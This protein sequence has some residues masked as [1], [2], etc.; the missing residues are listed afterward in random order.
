MTRMRRT[1]GTGSLSLRGHIWWI[2]YSHRGQPYPESSHSGDISEAKKLLAKRLGEIASGRFAGPRPEKGTI[3]DLADLVI[4]DYKHAQ[5]RSLDDVEYRTKLHI[6]PLLGSVKAARFGETQLKKYVAVRRQQGAE[7]S[8]INRDLSIIRRGFTLALQSDPP[9]VSRIPYI[10]KLSEDNTRAGF[11]EHEQYRALLD[12]LPSHLKCLLVVGFHVGCRIGELRQVRWPQ[13]DLGAK[14]IRLTKSQTKGK[15]DRT[16]PIYCDMVE[17][18]KF[19]KAAHDQDYADCPLVFHYLG[20]PLGSH[21]KGWARACKDA[22]LEGLHFHDLRR[23]AIRNME[24]AGIPRNVAMGI[25]GH[26]TEAVYRRYDIV[27]PRDLQLAAVR[28]ETYLDGLKKT[29]KEEGPE[30]AEKPSGRPN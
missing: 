1:R 21:L 13:V 8:T 25:S 22:G 12:K 4:E 5:K 9:L 11:V 30:T 3:A 23:S 17:W 14:E 28:M 7:N 10:K 6:R 15:K 24:R 18:L 2:F 29:T 16:L 20:R 27:S 19:Q 26:T